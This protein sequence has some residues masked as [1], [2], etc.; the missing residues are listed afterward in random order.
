[1]SKFISYIKKNEKCY[2]SHICSMIRNKTKLTTA[3]IKNKI[4]IAATLSNSNLDGAAEGHPSKNKKVVTLEKFG[5]I[6]K[7]KRS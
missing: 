3:I 7:F 4:Q 1:M 5:N 2:R 6:E